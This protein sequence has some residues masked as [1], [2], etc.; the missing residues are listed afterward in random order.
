ME[1]IHGNRTG[2]VSHSKARADTSR[3]IGMPVIRRTGPGLFTRA[4]MDWIDTA[5]QERRTLH[6]VVYPVGFF[7][8]TPNNLPNTPTSME[9]RDRYL[10]PESHGV[11]HWAATWIQP[12][13]L[14]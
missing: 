3:W 14:R 2:G 9:I 4:V 12:S 8:P 11:H 13:T 6:M 7:F 1:F 5:H 10:H